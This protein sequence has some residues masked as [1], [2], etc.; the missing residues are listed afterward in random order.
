ML[1]GCQANYRLRSCIPETVSV[2]DE[3]SAI[4]LMKAQKNSVEC[5]NERNAHIKDGVA[6]TKFIYWLKTHVGKEKITEVTAADY[7]EQK[8]REIP[9]F[10]DLSF[11]TIAGYKSNAAMMH[12]EAT[13][14][15]CA[16]LEPE[17]MLLVDS[18]GQYLGGTTDVT[19]TIV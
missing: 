8:R 13:P 4:Q 11:P 3:P 5:E 7:L 12:Y 1:D 16:T 17:G 15:N 10:L 6:V 19:R 9:E 18:G 2:V 14:D